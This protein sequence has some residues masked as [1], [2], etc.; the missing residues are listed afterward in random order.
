MNRRRNRGIEWGRSVY[1]GV[2]AISVAIVLLFSASR[3]NAAP[4]AVR[5]TLPSNRA[6]V[7]GMMTIRIQ[8]SASVTALKFYIDGNLIA[9]GAS[10]GG[11]PYSTSWNS[12]AVVNGTHTLFVSGY[13]SANQMIGQQTVSITVSNRKKA[14]ATRTPTPTATL[15]LTPTRTATTTPTPARTPTSTPTPTPSATRTPTASPTITATATTTATP[16]RTATLTPTV[17]RTATATSTRT[18]TPTPTTPPPSPTATTTAS[19]TVFYVAPNG[20]DSNNGSSGSPWLTIQ[21][22]ANSLKPGQTAIVEAGTYDERVTITS[23]GTSSEPIALEVASSADVQML[24]FNLSASYWVL[25]GF[26]VSTQTNGNNGIGI[27]ISNSASY[28]T[29][30][31]NYIHEL[32]HEGIVM[33][34]TV[35]YISVLNNR[36]WRAEMAG[37]QVD[38]LN[39]LIQGNEVWDTQQEP[40]IAGGIYSACV[41]PNGADA[42]AFRFFGQNHVFRS[43]YMHDIYYATTVNPDPHTDCFQT[44]G[45]AGESTNNILIDR[46]WCVWPTNGSLGS[47]GD[48]S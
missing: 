7:S 44:W 13:N 15:T 24:G 20:S 41:T 12:T 23:S 27:Y 1:S 8:E 48:V 6:T 47:M 34:P 14:S 30:E 38:G 45:E 31:N 4:P 43:N 46:N 42:D 2:S 36:I 17:T 19:G 26:D 35:S 3:I 25:N 5:I 37:A 18:P 32:C 33:D 39:N 9:S 10:V 22:A 28:D 29:I 21:H 11:Q 40:V 16:T